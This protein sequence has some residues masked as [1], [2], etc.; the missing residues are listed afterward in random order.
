M[1]QSDYIK[2]KKTSAMLKTN[3]F[4]PL[5]E[6]TTYLDNKI[7]YLE[8]QENEHIMF[9]QL[10]SPTCRKVYGME[11]NQETYAKC[12]EQS[13]KLNCYPHTNS[14]HRFVIGNQYNPSVNAMSSN[15]KKNC[16]FTDDAQSVYCKDNKNLKPISYLKDIHYINFKKNKY[17]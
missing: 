10:I 2:L 4:S 7:Y 9:N 6:Q 15:K 14:K 11:L 3:K 13:E 16:I 1:T 12:V 17:P 8:N 5:L